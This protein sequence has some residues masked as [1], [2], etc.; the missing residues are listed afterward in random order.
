MDRQ[1]RSKLG[2]RLLQPP[3]R[4]GGPRPAPGWGLLPAARLRAGTAPARAGPG[5]GWAGHPQGWP[6]AHARAGRRA[7]CRNPSRPVRARRWLQ[8]PPPSPAAQPLSAP[9]AATASAARPR[10]AG[11]EAGDP[12]RGQRASRRRPGAEG[13]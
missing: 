3:R 1:Q 7:P 8:A 13:R 10:A 9:A 6:T 5:V 12:A 4:A 11:P 2:R